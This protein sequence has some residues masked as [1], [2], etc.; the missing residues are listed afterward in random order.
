MPSRWHSAV[1]RA[2]TDAAATIASLKEHGLPTE[3]VSI[4]HGHKGIVAIELTVPAAHADG[5][6]RWAHGRHHPVRV[7]PLSAEPGSPDIV[8]GEYS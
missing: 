6:R 1:A 7:V 8:V 3:G 5:A 4:R 2:Q